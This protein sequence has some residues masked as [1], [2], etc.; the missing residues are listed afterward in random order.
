MPPL[1]HAPPTANPE[2]EQSPRLPRFKN[3]PFPWQQILPQ[4]IPATTNVRTLLVRHA[5]DLWHCA[6][7][8]VQGVGAIQFA[9]PKKIVATCGG[10]RILRPLLVFPCR[11]MRTELM[12]C[13]DR[14][15]GVTPCRL[16]FR[17]TNV[18]F[19]GPNARW[20]YISTIISHQSLSDRF[21]FDRRPMV[22]PHGIRDPATNRRRSFHFQGECRWDYICRW[23]ES[24]REQRL[25]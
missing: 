24:T 23:F 21:T 15:V 22:L 1:G 18:T 16:G 19:F 12:D 25:P 13:S 7:I 3:Q 9:N 8:P 10:W 4:R 20:E 5:D 11:L 2:V 6:R 14:P 17:G